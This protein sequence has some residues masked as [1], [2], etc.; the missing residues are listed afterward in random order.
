VFP[1]NTLKTAHSR[2]ALF[3]IPIGKPHPIARE[4]IFD[5][6]LLNKAGNTA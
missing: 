6:I 3:I 4:I 1:N 5:R 2:N